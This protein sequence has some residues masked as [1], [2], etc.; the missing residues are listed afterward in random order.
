[1]K[2]RI[3]SFLVVSMASVN[4][5]AASENLIWE[6]SDD[7]LKKYNVSILHDKKGFISITHK[8]TSLNYQLSPVDH[9]GNRDS[10]DIRYQ[11]YYRDI[12]V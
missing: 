3:V 10:N 7:N 2:T 11:I 1:M 6:A 9:E 4:L 12:P 5:Q 8:M